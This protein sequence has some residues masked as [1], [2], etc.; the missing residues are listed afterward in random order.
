[1]V[2]FNTGFQQ[3]RSQ[4]VQ[5]RKAIYAHIGRWAK[6]LSKGGTI[7]EKEMTKIKK[8]HEQ[9]NRSMREKQKLGKG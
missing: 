5:W 1:M 4:M 2:S 8:Y 7:K 3:K 6:T 9:V